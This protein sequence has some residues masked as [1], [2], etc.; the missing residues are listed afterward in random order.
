MRTERIIRRK[1]KLFMKYANVKSPYEINDG[2]CEE[3]AMDVIDDL[4]GYSKDTFELVSEEFGDEW[5]TV[6]PGFKSEFGNLPLEVR[7]EFDLPGHVWIFHKGKHYD[8]EAPDGVKNFFNLPIFKRA[9]ER[10]NQ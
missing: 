6:Q 8:A 7:K 5:A 3:F 9:V 10:I 2:Y 1:I 4:G